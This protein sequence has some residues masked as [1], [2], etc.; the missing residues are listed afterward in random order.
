MARQT[1]NQA[2][3]ISSFLCSKA[4]DSR[5]VPLKPLQMAR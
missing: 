4:S 3:I 1:A 2:N 5:R